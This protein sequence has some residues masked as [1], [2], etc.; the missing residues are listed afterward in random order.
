MMRECAQ[1]IPEYII[2]NTVKGFDIN[3]EDSNVIKIEIGDKSIEAITNEITDS[4]KLIFNCSKEIAFNMTDEI[5]CNL[6][7]QRTIVLEQ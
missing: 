7:I 4:I 5:V 6:P 3:F 1:S 2:G